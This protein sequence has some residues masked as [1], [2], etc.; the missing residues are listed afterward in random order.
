MTLYTYWRSG[1]SWR[2]RTALNL[3]GFTEEE[4]TMSFVHLVKDGG[5][6][7]SEEFKKLNPAEVSNFNKISYVIESQLVPAL[8]VHEDKDVVLTESLPI[9]EWLDETYPTKG[10]KLLPEG[11]LARFQCR[12]LCEIINSGT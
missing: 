12:R 9:M 2:V 6:Q 11:A 4:V 5:Q 1:C 10:E 3:K 8:V 7:H